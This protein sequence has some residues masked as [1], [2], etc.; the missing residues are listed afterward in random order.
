MGQKHRAGFCR[1][2]EENV[3]IRKKK[4]PLRQSRP[5]KTRKSRPLKTKKTRLDPRIK[6]LKNSGASEGGALLF[7]T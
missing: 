1:L 2:S 3:S 4:S 6:Q 7:Y 5:L